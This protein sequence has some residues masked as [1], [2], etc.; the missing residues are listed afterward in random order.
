MSE[1]TTK[2]ETD[3][4]AGLHQVDG[5][6]ENILDAAEELF[7]EK[8]IANTSMVE[9]ARKVGITKVTL[10]R[11]FANRD[12]IAVEI[13]IKMLE[14]ID[15]SSI[16]HGE[17]TEKSNLREVIQHRLR[18]F[19]T[20]RDAYRYVGMFDQLYLDLPSDSVIAQWT[21]E[22]LRKSDWR[23]S[24]PKPESHSS[25]DK[26]KKGVIFSNMIWFLEKLALRGELTWSDAEVPL[27]QHLKV[28]EDM[29]LAYLDKIEI[30]ESN[31]SDQSPN[32]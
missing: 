27:E 17:V 21:K 25:I 6:R 1:K 22:Q 24:K 30:S 26:G 15:Q 31:D 32:Q 23:K 10:Y 18:S 7:L 28:F 16:E 11:Y 20:V 2:S 19:E 8:G 29:V 12:E 9:I 13:Q 14:K 3:R 5:Q 4:N